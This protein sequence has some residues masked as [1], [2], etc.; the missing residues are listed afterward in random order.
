MPSPIDLSVNPTAS[1]Y[2]RADMPKKRP[3]D[4]QTAEQP[5]RLKVAKHTHVPPGFA[6]ALKRDTVRTV[7][8][9]EEVSV[10]RID[11]LSK[12]SAH[13]PAQNQS[14]LWELGTDLEIYA[15]NAQ[16]KLKRCLRAEGL[17]LNIPLGLERSYYK[18]KE[19]NPEQ[20]LFLERKNY[21]A[22]LIE[23]ANYRLYFPEVAGVDSGGAKKGSSTTP[24][25]EGQAF[26]HRREI[27]REKMKD[28]I[29]S[30]SNHLDKKFGGIDTIR[31][32]F[33]AI[34]DQSAINLHQKLSNT[35]VKERKEGG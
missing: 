14:R 13:T 31:G 5:Q 17:V 29:D 25:V 30:L 26:D 16:A 2:G 8:F 6:K 18:Y 12:T 21:K 24:K 23:K 27:R 1:D 35:D 19:G 11:D 22:L 3:S 28:S 32:R 7:T 15:N 20:Q 33:T 10:A 4:S 34:A 9:N